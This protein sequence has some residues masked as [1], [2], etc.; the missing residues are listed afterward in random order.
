MPGSKIQ[1]EFLVCSTVNL[2][3]AQLHE[4]FLA[5]DSAAGYCYS[6]N[7]SAARIWELIPSPVSVSSLCSALCGEFDIDVTQCQEQVIDF[8]TAMADAGLVRVSAE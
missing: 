7:A 4:D 1:P 8:L 6:M 3:F 2:P 5:I